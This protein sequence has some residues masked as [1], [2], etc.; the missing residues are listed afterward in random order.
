MFLLS[1][2]SLGEASGLGRP[3]IHF[4]SWLFPVPVPIPLGY[5]PIEICPR[6][7]LRFVREVCFPLSPRFPEFGFALLTRSQESWP[8]HSLILCGHLAGHPSIRQ[9]AAGT[10]QMW[11]Y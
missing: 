11:R 10:I 7:S 5:D 3:V 8:E 1:G 6:G 4:L 2:V 9:G